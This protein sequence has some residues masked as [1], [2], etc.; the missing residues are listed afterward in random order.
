MALQPTASSQ[1]A[2]PAAF[3]DVEELQVSL[4]SFSAQYGVGGLII[5]QITKGGTNNSTAYFTSTSRTPPWE[6]CQLWI[7]TT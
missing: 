2:N 7:R 5:N 6:R 1:N 4:S 3:E